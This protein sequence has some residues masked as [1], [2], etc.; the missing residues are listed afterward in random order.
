MW[1]NLLSGT[2]LYRDVGCLWKAEQGNACCLHTQYCHTYL[3]MNMHDLKNVKE[4][5]A[6]NQCAEASEAFRGLLP[7]LL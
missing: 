2:S 6:P 7:G 1:W 5:S 4:V 3:I